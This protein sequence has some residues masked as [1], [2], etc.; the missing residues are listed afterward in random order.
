MGRGTFKA[1]SDLRLTL[2]KGERDLLVR[3]LY[4]HEKEL[5][6]MISSLE[7]DIEKIGWN[8][9]GRY[10]GVSTFEQRTSE[11]GQNLKKNLRACDLLIK[12]LSEGDGE[13]ERV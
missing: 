6:S 10:E 3:I 2:D 9:K 8:R 4:E 7:S 1:T 13:S 5:K 11:W 12:R